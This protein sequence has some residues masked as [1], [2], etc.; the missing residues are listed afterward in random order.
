VTHAGRAAIPPAYTAMAAEYPQPTEVAEASE[1]QETAQD[2]GAYDAAY[3]RYI[4]RLR[5]TFQDV[6]DGKLAK[7]GPCLLELSEFLLGQAVELGTV[8]LAGRFLTYH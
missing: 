4:E 5:A 6:R 3:H 8:V 1:V 7:A 2:A